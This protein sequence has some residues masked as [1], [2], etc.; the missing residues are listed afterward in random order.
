VGT[1]VL[2]HHRP[3]TLFYIAMP[4]SITIFCPVIDLLKTKVL[5]CSATSSTDAVDFSADFSI[6][7]LIFSGGNRLPLLYIS[8]LLPSNRNTV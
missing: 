5:T 6:T 2:I 1:K 7:P 4:Q 8:H 3:E